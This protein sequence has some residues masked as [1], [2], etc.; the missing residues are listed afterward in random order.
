MRRYF[1]SATTVLA[2]ILAAVP[3]PAGQERP[4]SQSPVYMNPDLPIEERV[5]NLVSQM[6][7]EE[8]VSQLVNDAPAI[9][10]LGIPRYNWWNE[11]LH[12]VARAGLATVFPQAI[13]L[14]ATWDDA[15]IFHIA[16]AISDEARAKHHEFVRRGKRGIYEGLTFWSPNI[17]IFRD[18][19]WGRGMETYG[20]DPFLTGSLAVRFIRGLQGNDPRY[21]KVV[22][23]AKHYAVHSGPEPTRHTFDAVVDATDLWMTY[24]PQFEASVR[25]AHA[26]SVM[27]AYN[28][29]DGEACCA[30]PR[31]LDTILRREWG[32]DGY[33][34]SDCGAISDIYQT[35]KIVQTAPEAAALGVKAGCDLE[36][37]S[38]YESLA[39]AVAGGLVSEE[40]INRAVSRLFT[41]RF[42][43]G[44][45]DPP[46]RVP[47][48]GIP[49]RVV[50][51]QEHR[52]LALEAARKSIVL[53]RNDGN[54][55]PLRK[56]LRTIAVI[57]PNAND[58]EVLQGNYNGTPSDA[59]TPLRGIQEKVSGKTRV[60][61][62]LGCEWASN[63]PVLEV[64]PSSALFTAEGKR[65]TNGLRGEYFDNREFKGPPVFTRVDRQVDF[66]WWD[67]S[68][69]PRITDDDNFSVRW[70]G[71]LVPPVTGTYYLG[72]YG[73][74][75]FRIYLDDD[76]L[77]R[78]ENVHEPSKTYEKRTL[79]AGHAYRLRVEYFEKEGDALMQL[80]WAAPRRDLEKDAIQ[81]ADQSDAVIMFMGLSPR[82]EGEEMWVQVEGFKGGD[83][84]DLHLP[85]VQE[86]LIRAIH[87]LG[88]P[89]VL[90]LL[91]GSAVAV[92]WESG[93]IPAIVQS[94]YP[95]QAAGTAIA[96]VLFGDANPGGRLPVTFYSSVDQL[97]PFD[98]YSMAGRTYRY[99]K[100]TPLFPFGYGLSYTKFTYSDLHVPA[101]AEA[102]Q[103]VVVSVQVEN[104]G[105]RPGDEVVQLYLSDLEASVAVPTR[106]LVGFQ[107]ITL[108]PG[109][110]RVV[111][112]TIP[113]RQLSVFTGSAFVVEPGTFELSVGGKQPGFRGGIDASTTD[114]LTA[115]FEVRAR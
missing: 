50:D 42:K 72:G 79:E 21:L 103:D 114:V 67:R 5:A 1:P 37:G 53:L 49:Y 94:W 39:K 26:F 88:K 31:L 98:D 104:A 41:A 2:A 17:N 66:H 115:R 95:G 64:V 38:V 75:G 90:V 82:L 27:C 113:P 30:S 96:D 97:P 76:L 3:S 36:C 87:G 55:L 16:T 58:V 9:E 105:D 40:D 18:P 85:A 46:E 8:K 32:F 51:S 34:V 65:R 60:L 77:T 83:R 61:Y 80:L 14:A 12:G 78:F 102:D 6:T 45:F 57:G 35:H 89:I 70:T 68:P 74:T 81:V 63:L 22:A 48:A 25:E 109:E 24:L 20:E 73:L 84:T 99:F 47:Y 69:D 4:V 13:G 54:L 108:K 10:R 100:G 106:T 107:R 112:F 101:A 86:S 91:S 111:E 7:L 33:V 43:L 71:E 19:R 59:I 29:L 52:S 23:T 93:N 11:C 62:A 28:R 110:R 15:L 44:M 56:D 92:N